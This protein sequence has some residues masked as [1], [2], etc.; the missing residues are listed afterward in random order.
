ECVTDPLSCYNCLTPLATPLV[1]DTFYLSAT[2]LDGCSDIDT[3]F[4]EVIPVRPVYIPNAFSP[5]GDGIND[6]FTAFG[7]AVATS[8]VKFQVYS[9]WGDLLFQTGSIPLNNEKLGWDGR[10]ADGRPLKPGV[11]AYVIEIAFLD[12]TTGVYYGDVV[13]VR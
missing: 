4:V 1:S 7:G 13:L 2:D 10:A 9:R 8:I 3:V 12:C 6:Y 11:Y 5:N